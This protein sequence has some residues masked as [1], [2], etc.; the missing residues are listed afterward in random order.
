M[1][2]YKNLGGNSGVVSYEL[3]ADSISVMFGDGWVYRYAYAS[4]GARNIEHMKTLAQAG[5]G[6]NA[7]IN[8]TVQKAY[9][10]KV[11][12]YEHLRRTA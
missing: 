5:R 4:A 12:R 10:S 1:T 3:A 2:P 6:L 7:F 8:T 9:A 11:R